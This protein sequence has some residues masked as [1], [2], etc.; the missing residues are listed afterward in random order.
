V[1]RRYPNNLTARFWRAPVHGMRLA[2]I[3][4]V[5]H[6]VTDFQSDY[7]KTSDLSDPHDFHYFWQHWFRM[8][9]YPHD[10]RVKTAEIDWQGFGAQLRRMSTFWGRPGLMKAIEASFHMREVV[11]AYPQ[12]V[13]VFIQRDL[14]DSA[15]SLLKGRRDNFGRAD[16]W[17][18]QVPPPEQFR[19]LTDLPWHEQ[20][21]GQF[22]ALLDMYEAQ[23]AELPTRNILRLSYRAL[24]E[25]PNAVMQLIA[26]RCAEFGAPLVQRRSI[27]P[28]DVRFSV[29][30][31]SEAD[32]ALLQEGLARFGL[33]ARHVA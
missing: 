27:D 8:D 22:K 4:G 21:G 9:A 20:I 14:I 1:A 25:D 2:K 26:A 31:G 17:Y 18:G 23:I 11:A 12:A 28:A 33:E 10:P 30:K 32:L 16:A 19:E 7:G 6:I 15:V 29:G 3:L 5:E 13:F 24:C